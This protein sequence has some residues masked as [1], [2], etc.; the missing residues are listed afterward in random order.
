MT[1]VEVMDMALTP[2][3]EAALLEEIRTLEDRLLR[4]E[5]FVQVLGRRTEDLQAFHPQGT[6]GVDLS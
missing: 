3:H 4:M 6:N 1:T 5:R 2:E